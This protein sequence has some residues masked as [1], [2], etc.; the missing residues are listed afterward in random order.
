MRIL[1]IDDDAL[2]RGV[3][4]TALEADGHSVLAAGN[5]LDG[6]RLLGCNPVDCVVCD[7]YMPGKEGLETMQEIRRRWP[8]LPILAISGN[9][10][11]DAFSPLS[12]AIKFGATARLQKPFQP[13]ELTAAVRALKAAPTGAA[14]S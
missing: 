1:L 10:G 8:G 6:L 11:S 3:A 4:A 12:I 14:P 7:I 9:P 2:F 13:S 5:G